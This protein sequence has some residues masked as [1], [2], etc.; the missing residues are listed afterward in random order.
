MNVAVAVRVRVNVAVPGTV[1]VGVGVL[2][3]VAV[4]VGVP[5]SSKYISSMKKTAGAFAVLA[6]FIPLKIPLYAK[7]VIGTVTLFHVFMVNAPPCAYVPFT[8]TVLPS[9]AP[10]SS[11]IMLR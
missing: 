5:F 7:L 8:V 9:E 3:A 11:F 2:V 10:E 1:F 4:K 6:S